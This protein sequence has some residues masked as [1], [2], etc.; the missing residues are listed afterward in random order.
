ML[1]MGA[2]SFT[3]VDYFSWVHVSQGYVKFHMSAL[4]LMGV[5]FHMGYCSSHR[6][7]M[8]HGCS[9]IW[10]HCFTLVH[11]V[12]HEC[13]MFQWVHYIL[14]GCIIVHIKGSLYFNWCIIFYMVVLLHWG[15][16]CVSGCIT[17]HMS[18]LFHI[19]APY[20]TWVHVL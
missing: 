3:W 8:F 17:F 4:C 1:H 9:F 16:L 2:L 6:C 19:G 11:Y 5:L 18:A 13:V 12:S 7:I 15:M 10:V 14:H 20:F